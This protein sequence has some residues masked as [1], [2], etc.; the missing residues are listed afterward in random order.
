L[1]LSALFPVRYGIFMKLLT[2]FLLVF[3]PVYLISSLM[4]KSGVDIIRQQLLVLMEQK[5]DFFVSSM[6]S[7]LERVFQLQEDFLKDQDLQAISIRLDTLTPYEQ[8]KTIN[9]LH[10]KLYSLSVSSRYIK[11]ALI[12]M[13]NIQ[14][15]LSS[16]TGQTELKPQELDDLLRKKISNSGLVALDDRIYIPMGFP[17]LNNA[18]FFVVIELS[19]SKIRE[20]LADPKAIGNGTSY[21]VSNEGNSSFVIPAAGANA[22]TMQFIQQTAAVHDTAFRLDNKSY[23]RFTKSFK[24]S[25]WSFV[26]IVEEG[27]MLQPV[28]SFKIWLTVLYAIAGLVVL[29]VSLLLLRFI[30]KPLRK[31]M[32]ALKMVEIGQFN[33]NLQHSHKDEFHYLYRQFNQMTAQLKILVQQVYEQTIRSQKAELKQLQSQVNPHFLYNSLYILYRMAQAEDF[34]GVSAMS[35]HM[36]DYFKFITQNKADFIPLD[37]ELQHAKT[38]TLIQQ[39]RFGSRIAF[40]YTEYGSI[41]GWEVPRL[42]IQPFIENAIVHGLED[43]HKDGIV[44]VRI[45]ATSR[46]LTIEI[47]D[48]GKGVSLEQLQKWDN[49]AALEDEFRDH[50]LWNVHRRL[51]LRYGNSS[52]VQLQSN[53]FG[54]LTATL[55]I[56]TE[57][58]N[59]DE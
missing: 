31:L 10:S 18:M 24:F 50:A 42:I 57:G 46:R 39:I 30:H 43:T 35:K 14:R 5:S 56:L 12:I 37:K 45:I 23:L 9:D 25:D 2:T 38:Y 16:L 59:A 19:V 22:E 55:S 52:G 48:N 28:Y 3:I 33:I 4:N 6:D 7:E 26:T 34:E 17:H 8:T 40:Q 32:H 44:H 29:V 1:K 47:E 41:D 15:R 21:I 53:H 11:E 58:E 36:G 51:Q 13:P 27:Q 49:K 20:E 54:G